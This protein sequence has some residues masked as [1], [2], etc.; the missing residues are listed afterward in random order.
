M[1]VITFLLMFVGGVA[2]AGVIIIAKDTSEGLLLSYEGTINLDGLGDPT[3]QLGPNTT[4][5]FTTD[6][7]GGG[8]LFAHNM[9]LTTWTNE[10][11]FFPHF[12]K[13]RATSFRRVISDAGDGVSVFTDG[14]GIYRGYV[15]GAF[16]SG[17]A[18]YSGSISSYGLVAG[19]YTAYLPHDFVTLRIVDV[20]APTTGLLFAIGLLLLRRR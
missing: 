4:T 9:N 12:A 18:V 7:R 3:F 10:K 17:F 11:I 20:P 19:D 15:S 14:F 16:L 8:V 6:P 13:D 2:N 5:H 1:R